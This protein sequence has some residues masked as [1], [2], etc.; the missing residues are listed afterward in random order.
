ML[1]CSYRDEWIEPLKLYLILTLAPE[2][3]KGL[4]LSCSLTRGFC[5][6]HGALFQVNLSDTVLELSN[7]EEISALKALFIWRGGMRVDQRTEQPL[8]KH[9]DQKM[10]AHTFNPRIP[11]TEIPLDPCEFKATLETASHFTRVK[12]QVPLASDVSASSIHSLQH[13]QLLWSICIFTQS[14]NSDPVSS[15][16]IPVCD[17]AT[18]N[19]LR[20]RNTRLKVSLAKYKIV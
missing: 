10:V 3:L 19:V 17:E 14:E 1:P 2:L 18:L 6:Q 8:D 5:S 13:N 15:L 12:K 20:Y 11:E 7:L 4:L 9:K 16:E